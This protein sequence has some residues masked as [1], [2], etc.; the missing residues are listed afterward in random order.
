MD[1]HAHALV[2]AQDQLESRFKGG[3]AE[4]RRRLLAPQGSAAGGVISGSEW[5]A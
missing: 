2:A 4:P 5:I 1:M 3:Y